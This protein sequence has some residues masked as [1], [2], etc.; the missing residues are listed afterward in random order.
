[1]KTIATL[2]TATIMILQ[3]YMVQAHEGHD[4]GEEKKEAPVQE[5]NAWFTVNSISETFEA[6]L[7]YSPV[8]KGE[9]VYLQLFL[10]DFE[11]NSSE[12]KQY[13]IPS[14]AGNTFSYHF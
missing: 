7:R 5:G 1:M 8:E 12:N 9:E 13:R 10:S 3:G 4:H 6:V 14:K 11:T 2:L